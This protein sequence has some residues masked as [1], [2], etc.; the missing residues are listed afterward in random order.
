VRQDPE[1]LVPALAG[2]GLLLIGL[3]VLIIYMLGGGGDSHNAVA[4]D[5]V[6]ILKES[7]AILETVKDE[8]SAKAA[9][10]KIDALAES[11][12]TRYKALSKLQHAETVSL[13]KEHDIS[14]TIIKHHMTTRS[15]N[16]AEGEGFEASLNGLSIHWSHTAFASK[17]LMEPHFPRDPG[18]I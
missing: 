14:S 9:A 12:N 13:D 1:A 11:V 2:G 7:T 16:H 6:S 15:K 4:K 3:I 10:P 5:F 18:F 8:A 17:E